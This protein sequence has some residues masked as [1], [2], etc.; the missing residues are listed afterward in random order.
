M[1]HAEIDFALLRWGKNVTVTKRLGYKRAEKLLIETDCLNPGEAV[2][3][4]S[5]KAKEAPANLL[6]LILN[7]TSN[8]G[9]PDRKTSE[10]HLRFANADTDEKLIAFVKDFGPVL[11]WSD[12]EGEE[13]GK[14]DRIKGKVKASAEESLQLLRAERDRFASLLRLIGF[15]K[16]PVFVR[17]AVVAA[18][19]EVHQRYLAYGDRPVPISSSRLAIRKELGDVDLEAWVLDDI[20]GFLEANRF[21]AQVVSAG[22]KKRPMLVVLPEVRMARNFRGV[23]YGLLLRELEGTGLVR[24]CDNKGCGVTF[25]PDRVNQLFCNKWCGWKAASNKYWEKGLGR[26]RR[27]ERAVRRRVRGR[28]LPITRKGS[29]TKRSEGLA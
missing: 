10:P 12:V 8:W 21:R 2:P 28:S 7:E 25:R 29:L 14:A 19:E 3:L 5:L 26:L 17:K 22:P 23:L 11:A 16:E 24:K 9:N 18:T 1:R 13:E 15:L 4:S 27:Q 20:L 6:P